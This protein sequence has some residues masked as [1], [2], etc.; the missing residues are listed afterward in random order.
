LLDKGNF[1]IDT[2]DAVWWRQELY[3]IP[4]VAR[5]RARLAAHT[6]RFRR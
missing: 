6:R 4:V 5:V 1:I 3:R 2:I